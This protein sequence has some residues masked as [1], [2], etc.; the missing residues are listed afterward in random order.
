MIFSGRFDHRCIWRL[1]EGELCFLTTNNVIWKN[2]VLHITLPDTKNHLPRTF[3]IDG[4]FYD[5]LK[6][7]MDLRPQKQATN[8]FFLNYCL[9]KCTNQPIGKNKLSSMPSEIAAYQKLP[10]PEAYTGHTF[11]RTAATILADTG[12]DLL[13]IKRFGGWKSDS[14]AEGYIEDSINNKRKRANQ[15]TEVINSKIS[16]TKTSGNENFSPNKKKLEE[17]VS[18]EALLS[19]NSASATIGKEK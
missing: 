13:S 15:L 7:Y 14:V 11:R 4:E 19:K 17:Q 9:G 6:K 2:S 10:N 8:R 1:R 5:M 12:A 18:L 16:S 3:V